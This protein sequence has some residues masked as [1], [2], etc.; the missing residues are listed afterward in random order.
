MLRLSS[1]RGRCLGTRGLAIRSIDVPVQ[2]KLPAAQLGGQ[3]PRRAVVAPL[4]HRMILNATK[5]EKSLIKLSQHRTLSE[6]VKEMSSTRPVGFFD[7]LEPYAGRADAG[8]AIKLIASKLARRA[9]SRLRIP[10][11]NRVLEDFDRMAINIPTESDVAEL[12]KHRSDTAARVLSGVPGESSHVSSQ[13]SVD[14]IPESVQLHSDLST[15]SDQHRRLKL[16]IEEM[17]MI[18]HAMHACFSEALYA[19]SLQANPM[20]PTIIP[21]SSPVQLQPATTENRFAQA[22]RAA[23]TPWV[24]IQQTLILMTRDFGIRRTPQDFEHAMRCAVASRDSRAAFDVLLQLRRDQLMPTHLTTTMFLLLHVDLCHHREADVAFYQSQLHALETAISNQQI[25]PESD[26]SS[27][28]AEQLLHR[29]SLL[30]Q[31]LSRAKAAAQTQL[32]T[33]LF[34]LR[35]IHR[36]RLARIG[37]LLT[38][39]LSIM[40]SRVNGSA[41]SEDSAL[42]ALRLRTNSS[43]KS[44]SS[45]VEPSDAPVVPPENLPHGWT[46]PES[47]PIFPNRPFVAR[48]KHLHQLSPLLNQRMQQLVMQTLLLHERIETMT[49]PVFNAAMRAFSATGDY[50]L[51]PFFFSDALVF[52]IPLSL[53]LP[54]A[55]T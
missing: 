45:S 20:V 41:R 23:A 31:M 14:P 1:L 8:G 36:L 7:D 30:Q 3:R 38:R 11:I 27:Y 5:Q 34:D 29:Q 33:F 18:E 39:T 35:R 43:S 16:S 9:L 50:S 55:T 42:P 46:P 25:D 21:E 37:P 6:A 44:V 19:F 13:E 51:C 10:A 2:N 22:T 17:S 28:A 48:P 26:R 54:K 47:P 52:L 32:N 53:S 12:E 49:M 15:R 40:S 4:I 24:A